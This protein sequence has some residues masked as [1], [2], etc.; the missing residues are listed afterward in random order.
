MGW[1][2]AVNEQAHE[3][4]KG[5]CKDQE[6]LNKNNSGTKKDAGADDRMWNLAGGGTP[7]SRNNGVRRNAWVMSTTEWLKSGRGMVWEA[8]PSDV[9]WSM[10]QRSMHTK[11][12][13]GTVLHVW[14]D[15]ER[16]TFFDE[17]RI[18]LNFQSGSIL[19]LTTDQNER[20]PPGGIKNF[21][22]FMQLVD[23][24]K[25]TSDNPPVPNLVKIYYN[26]NLFPKLTLIGMFDS[27]GITFTDS[28]QEPNQVTGWGADFIVYETTPALSANALAGLQAN[29]PLLDIWD[30]IKI[31][32]TP[33]GG[34]I[35]SKTITVP[36]QRR[37]VCDPIPSTQ[38]APAPGGNTKQN[39]GNTFG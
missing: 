28:S 22:D 20:I 4:F 6:N 9:T 33:N 24:P 21:Y 32:G 26:S 13:R 18:H 7:K 12:L 34:Q 39:E 35:P 38:P 8:N 36:I 16:G 17:F 1:L 29:Q 30:Q 37:S 14:P 15:V 2:D 3:T 5:L 10:P 11:N 31:K 23:C 25:L 27:N 19:P